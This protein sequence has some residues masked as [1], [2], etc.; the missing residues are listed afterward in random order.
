MG[1]PFAG[2]L[3][4]TQSISRDI[5]GGCTT[6][7]EASD[8]TND[9]A[10]DLCSPHRAPRANSV[11]PT[12][13]PCNPPSTR[14]TKKPKSK[15]TDRTPTFKFKSSPAGATF[16]CKLDKGSYEACTSPET[17]RKLK[18][19]KHTFSVRAKNQNGTDASP[20]KATFE[21]VKKR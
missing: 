7:L 10:T 14:L 19:G 15:T 2:V 12:E 16:K 13:T 8:D 4:A 20:A 1:T 17:T 21:V 3:P 18:R 6:L 9:V 5:S 11:T